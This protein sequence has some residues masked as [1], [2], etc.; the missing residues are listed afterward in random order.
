MFLARW[1]ALAACCLL[2]AVRIIIKLIDLGG[3]WAQERA[4]AEDR[5][6]QLEPLILLLTRVG[7][8]LADEHP[9]Q[10]G[11]VGEG[12][13]RQQQQ[14]AP[15]TPALKRFVDANPSGEDATLSAIAV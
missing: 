6:G 5:E 11:P 7:R 4:L 13:Q 12:P 14:V 2:L 9:G 15:H 1:V 3:A 8:V 10:F